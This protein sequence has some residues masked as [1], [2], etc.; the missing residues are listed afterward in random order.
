M[1][2]PRGRLKKRAKVRS[3]DVEVGKV[4]VYEGELY[5]E[6]IISKDTEDR[7]CK[8]MGAAAGMGKSM[9]AT[10]GMGKSM[11]ATAGVGKAMGA[12]AGMGRPL[13][14]PSMRTSC[15]GRTSSRRVWRTGSLRTSGGR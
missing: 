4:G 14:Q 9:V 1:G 8:S 3:S 11:G 13:A 12:I 2:G 5:W 7:V 15:S 10:A 6:E